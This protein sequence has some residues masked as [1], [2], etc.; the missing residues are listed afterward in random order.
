MQRANIALALAATLA[1]GCAEAQELLG[2]IAQDDGHGHGHG[3]GGGPATPPPPTSCGPTVN[4]DDLYS[5]I[6]ADLARLDADDRPF[7]RYVTLANR[8]NAGVCGSE[9]DQDR[10]AIGELFNSLSIEATISRPVPIDA[11]ELTFRVDLRD[12]AWDREIEVDGRRFADAWEAAL[13]SSPYA[14]ELTGPDADDAK[15]DTGTAVPLLNFD[16]LADVASQS[17]L[18]YALIDVPGS[19][20]ELL[21]DT[22][23][24]DVGQNRRDGTSVL[25][26]T[27]R[28]R[29]SRA[30]RLVERNPLEVRAGFI[31]R[32]FDYLD[33]SGVSIFEDPLSLD[34]DGSVALF[35]L[36]NGLFGF[37]IFDGEGTRRDDS[38]I[39]LD[40]NQINFRA[41]VAISCL[42]CHGP[43]GIIPV[44]DEVRGVVQNDADELDPERVAD[45]QRLYPPQAELDAL[46][47]SDADRYTRARASAGLDGEGADP[48]GLALLRFDSDLG[49]EQIAGDLWVP[50]SAIVA[51]LSELPPTFG[52]PFLDRDDYSLDF[53]AAICTV[54]ST[55]NRPIGCP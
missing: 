9:L 22:L 15:A 14:I 44:V 55:E 38:D 52:A 17:S 3:H 50:Q 29:I 32:A 1:G 41:T 20:D 18:Y 35:T 53:A 37:A 47:E 54:A 51:N 16:A 28:S 19:A 7:Q 40:T 39:L 48:L 31:W 30:D 2:D 6:A 21:L 4:A 46:F 25:A 10:A 33:E 26:G 13:A 24:I 36:P 5:T 49:L 23:G 42:N 8:F 12:Y 11:D 34:S 43:I 45:V 27:T